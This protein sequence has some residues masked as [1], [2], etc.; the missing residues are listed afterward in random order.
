MIRDE[1]T[2]M[3]QVSKTV[4][5]AYE[6]GQREGIEQGIEKGIEKML[7]GLFARRLHRA[8]TPGEQRALTARAAVDLDQTQEKALTLE[9]EALAAW[10]LAPTAAAK[11]RAQRRKR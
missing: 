6:L 4:R 5:D 1:P 9:G 7:R 10:L 8:L 3:I 11:P 2:D